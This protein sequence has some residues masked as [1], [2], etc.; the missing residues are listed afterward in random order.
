MCVCVCVCVCVCLCVCVRVCVE[1]RERERERVTYVIEYVC[2]MGKTGNEF[3]TFSVER[4]RFVVQDGTDRLIIVVSQVTTG[5]VWENTNPNH[6]RW[7]MSGGSDC[8]YTTVK[9]MQHPLRVNI[10]DAQS[11]EREQS[12]CSP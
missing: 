7:L 2:R 10:R 5:I 12:L 1:E 3:P 4:F 9:Y 11:A 8:V 6:N